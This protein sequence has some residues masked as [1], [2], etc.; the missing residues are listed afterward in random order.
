MIKI[1]KWLRP[2]MAITSLFLARSNATSGGKGQKEIVKLDM[3][4]NKI[5]GL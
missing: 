1:D 5:N 4:D 3:E 2:I